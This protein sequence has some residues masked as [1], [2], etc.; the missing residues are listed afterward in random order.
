MPFPSKHAKHKGFVLIVTLILLMAVSIVVLAGMK[1]SVLEERMSGNHMDRA[2]AK[3]AAEQAITQGLAKLQANAT[4]CLENGCSSTAGTVVAGTGAAITTA[5][6]PSVWSDTDSVVV[7]QAVGQVSS[8]KY[9]IN[10]LN[11]SAFTNSPKD[12]CKA[13]SVMGRG[14]GQNS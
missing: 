1:G 4:E 3:L 7:S 6:V 2:R 10:W 14:V 5:N 9:L 13:Y 11:N 8:A 12:N